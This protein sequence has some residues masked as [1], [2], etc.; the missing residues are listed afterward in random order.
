MNTHAFDLISQNYVVFYCY[1][2]LY[3]N[4]LYNTL[5]AVLMQKQKE[6]KLFSVCYIIN[7]KDNQ[8]SLAKSESY[9]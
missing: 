4:F 7:Q 5:H 1:I 2:S 6:K 3:L 9:I 8:F